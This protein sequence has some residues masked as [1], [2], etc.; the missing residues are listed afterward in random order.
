MSSTAAASRFVPCSASRPLP[1]A[2]GKHGKT[3]K[4]DGKR[5]GNR[6]KRME[7]DENGMVLATWPPDFLPNPVI[8][9]LPTRRE[10][11]RPRF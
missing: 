5:T 4:N 3:A 2:C 9:R 7:T 1:R 8:L 6:Q 11:V 10:R